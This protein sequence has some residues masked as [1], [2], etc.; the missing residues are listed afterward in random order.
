MR[1]QAPPGRGIWIHWASAEWNASSS[2][3]EVFPQIANFL[4]PGRDPHRPRRR[5]HRGLLGGGRGNSANAVDP[6]GAA[7]GPTL[8]FRL[9]EFIAS[10]RE[11]ARS[12]AKRCVARRRRRRARRRCCS[13]EKDQSGRTDDSARP[14]AVLAARCPTHDSSF[15]ARP[16]A[17]VHI[18]STNSRDSPVKDRQ[19]ARTHIAAKCKVIDLQG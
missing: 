12:A 18:R 4:R 6:L 1:V 5:L 2:R 13:R 17:R 11:T 15:R 3:G 7:R 16:Q 10:S 14:P 19:P 8:N 9:V